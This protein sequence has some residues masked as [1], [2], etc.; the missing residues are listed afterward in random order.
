MNLAKRSHWLPY[1]LLTLTV[2]F[3]SGNFILGRGIRQLIPPIA[4]NFWR[5]VGALVILLPF[6]LPV[7]WRQRR[8]IAQHWKLL[9]LMSIPAIVIFNAFIYTALQSTTAVNTVLVNAM[10]PILIALMAWLFFREH[11]TWRQSMGVLV[12]MAGLVFIITHG[13]PAV[14][15]TFTF[16]AGDLW[17]LGAALAWALYSVMLRRRPAA[18]APLTFLTVIVACGVMISLPFYLWEYSQRGGF[19]V[20]TASM[21]GI[22]YVCLFPS[23][24]SYLFWNYGVERVGANR[25]GIFF[26]L[27]PVFAIILAFIFLNEVL[28]GYHLIGMGLIFSGIALTTWPTK[29]ATSPPHPVFKGR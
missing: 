26:H 4:L 10:I 1:L 21:A 18:M 11:L 28:Q 7:V 17:T 8:L 23:V 22:I 24:L 5:W 20:T 2:L 19:A 12:S 15:L 29:G 14:I 13:Q 25:A 9:V 16:S 27:M 6:S 3:W